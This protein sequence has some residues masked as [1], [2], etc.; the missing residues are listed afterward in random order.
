MFLLFHFLTVKETFNDFWTYDPSENTWTWINGTAG[1]NNPGYYGTKGVPDS[2]N[3]PPGRANS[4]F[5][6]DNDGDFWLFGGYVNVGDCN[7]LWKYI[8]S[9]NQWVWVSGSNI[10]GQPGVYG[11]KGVAD[12]SNIPG[13]R[14]S[15]TTWY[16]KDSNVVYIF[17]GEGYD[18][19]GA[20]GN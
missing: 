8:V 1:T 5:W 13:A 17:G 4:Y 3:L 15:G 9:S 7:D 6:V 18:S 11:T 20:I 12:P 19:T 2:S 14:D 10:V 16:N